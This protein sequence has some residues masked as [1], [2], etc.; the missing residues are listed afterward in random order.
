MSGNG[1]FAAA[2]LNLPSFGR[3]WVLSIYSQRATVQEIASV[4][5]KLAADFP[6]VI[7]GDWNA[8]IADLDYGG[9]AVRPMPYQW[10]LDRIAR[11]TL[12]DIWRTTHPGERQYTRKSSRLDYFL[13]SPAI[14]RVAVESSIVQRS[15]SDHLPV[16][17]RL[18]VKLP[19]TVPAERA[20]P[21]GVTKAGWERVQAK[22]AA[23]PAEHLTPW[24]RVANATQA[25]KGAAGGGTNREK[26]HL[27][28]DQRRAP[29][30]PK[31]R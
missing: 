8:A 2:L 19:S 12:V 28:A 10:L 4:V 23:P 3:M 14:A 11:G 6:V 25:G 26:P 1:L 21:Q 13:T 30:D 16:D 24:E 29:S 27:C 31:A 18:R 5:D 15:G 17:L 9:Q 20:Q 22:L 7:G